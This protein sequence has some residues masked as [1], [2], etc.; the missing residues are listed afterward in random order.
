M[1]PRLRR[2]EIGQH[3]HIS[4]KYLSFYAA[5]MAWREDRGRVDNGG[6]QQAALTA[7]LSHPVSQV[8]VGYWQRGR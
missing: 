3:R 4:G 2:A 7:A 6:M 5:G 8:W 1:P